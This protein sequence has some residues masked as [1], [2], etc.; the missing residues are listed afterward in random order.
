MKVALLPIPVM[1]ITICVGFLSCQKSGSPQDAACSPGG[2]TPFQESTQ[3]VEALHLKKV[4][5]RDPNVNNA[6]AFSLL[7]PEGWQ[8]QG[9][10]EWVLDNPVMPATIRFRV[11]NPSGHEELEIFPNLAL[12]W[13]DNQMLMSMFPLGSRYFGAEV[14]PPVGPQ[15][16]LTG[17]VIP[18]SRGNAAGLKVLSAGAMPEL[19]QALRAGAS[20]PGMQ[21]FGDAARARIE[22]VKDGIPVE[23]DFFAVV[24]GYSYPVQTMQG[25]ATYTNW[26]V[27]YIFS[28]KAAKGKLDANAT[29]FRAMTDSFRVTPQWFNTCNQVVDILVR[30]QLKFIQSMGELS[31]YISQTN[32]EISD[33]MMQSY[34]ERQKIYDRIGEKISETIR[35]TEHYYNPIEG[36]EVELPG[37][38]KHVWTNAGGEY[39]LTDSPGYNPNEESNKA[40]QEI[41]RK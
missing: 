37:G 32:S 3:T 36:S 29:L 39:I 19:A 26:Y 23:E 15:E 5:Y 1:V 13:S 31:R 2:T 40:W 12:F 6:E 9:G 14:R 8:F 25:V 28:Y 30:N 34:N 33:S 41:G 38:Y 4:S 7:I 20:Q 24:E 18:R 27:D 21:T 10:V 17:I 11:R 22:Y 35:G 16:A